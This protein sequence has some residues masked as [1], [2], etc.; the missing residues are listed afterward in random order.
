MTSP[1]RV[2]VRWTSVER[3]LREEGF[4]KLARRTRLKLGQ[5][6]LRTDVPKYAEA[7]KAE[8]RSTSAWAAICVENKAVSAPMDEKSMYSLY[9]HGTLEK[10]SK[11]VADFY[12]ELRDDA[13]V[14]ARRLLGLGCERGA[15][16]GRRDLPVVGRGARRAGGCARLVFR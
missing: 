1:Q 3:V 15:R 4:P 13:Q 10:H 7:V 11:V 6:V 12:E 14:L 9:V 5:T 2:V 16:G 8:M